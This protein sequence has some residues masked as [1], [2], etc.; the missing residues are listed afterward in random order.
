MS[1]ISLEN[2]RSQFRLPRKFEHPWQINIDDTLITKNI[3]DLSPSGMAFKAPASFNLEPGQIINLTIF[4]NTENQFQCQGR[5]LWTKADFSDSRTMKLFGVKFENLPAA[6]DTRI[7]KELHKEA[8]KAHWENPKAQETSRRLT[9]ALLNSNNTV[10]EII[11]QVI[12]FLL[13]AAFIIASHLY[14]RSH[15]E[16][17]IEYRFNQ[18]LVKKLSHF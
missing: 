14:Q 6:L 10:T 4:L 13:I 8:I 2:R 17:S 18:G 15:P 9:P 11:G 7:A 12:T 1:A 16:D 5:I 3:V